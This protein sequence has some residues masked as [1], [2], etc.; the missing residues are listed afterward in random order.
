MTAPGNGFL[1]RLFDGGCGGEE[2]N[3]P[4]AL[5]A[6]D[7]LSQFVPPLAWFSVTTRSPQH[8]KHLHANRTG[9]ECIHLNLHGEMDSHRHGNLNGHR[10]RRDGNEFETS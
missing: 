3:L 1:Y 9:K 7:Q 6:C 4:A 8:R 5:P 10:P 2:S